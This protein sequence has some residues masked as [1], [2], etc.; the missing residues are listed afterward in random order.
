MEQS[1]FAV[2]P[3][4]GVEN[5]FPR[6]A[7]EAVLQRD[8]TAYFPIPRHQAIRST[9][10]RAKFAPTAN[11]EPA[12]TDDRSPRSTRSVVTRKPPNTSPSPTCEARTTG[13]RLEQSHSIAEP[14][15]AVK[16]DHGSPRVP[17]PLVPVAREGD[18]GPY[19]SV[20]E[21]GGCGPRSRHVG[22]KAIMITNRDR[23]WRTRA[24]GLACAL[25]AVGTLPAQ[26]QPPKR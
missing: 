13:S 19:Q 6:H 22:R 5:Y 26:R 20:I 8:L 10:S 7:W 15:E 11:S 4:Y 14:G 17:C 24:A 2:L 16:Q 3:H 23:G 21:L 18:R 25:A 1:P 9:L 12:P